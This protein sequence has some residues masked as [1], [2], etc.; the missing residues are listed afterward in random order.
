MCVFMSL[1]TGLSSRR[2]NSEMELH[3]GYFGMGHFCGLTL[4]H[5]GGKKESYFII[6][7]N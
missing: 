3:V 7:E 2:R 4:N 6:S 1:N 5:L